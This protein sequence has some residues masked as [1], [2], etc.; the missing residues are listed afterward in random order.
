M[1]STTRPKEEENRWKPSMQAWSP[2]VLNS[3]MQPES[4]PMSHLSVQPSSPSVSSLRLLP[5]SSS[6]STFSGQY[7]TSSLSDLSVTS[8]VTTLVYGDCEGS[9]PVSLTL[10]S[11]HQRVKTCKGCQHKVQLLNL[12]RVNNSS[13]GNWL[14]WKLLFLSLKVWVQ[15]HVF[16][17]VSHFRPSI[18]PRLLQRGCQTK[19]TKRTPVQAFHMLSLFFLIHWIFFY[20]ATPL[21]LC[22]A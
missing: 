3:R 4:P 14:Q 5:D 6:V 2:P 12:R 1:L 9:T 8:V 21:L 13:E 22:T 18:L 15:K 19:K 10:V 20:Y 7:Y 17:S 16:Y 11:G